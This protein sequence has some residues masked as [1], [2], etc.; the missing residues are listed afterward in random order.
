M[1]RNSFLEYNY[2]YDLQAYLF[3]VNHD[4]CFLFFLKDVHHHIIAL[5]PDLFSVPLLTIICEDLAVS[6]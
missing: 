4:S 1:I 6:L 2:Y 3:I 5:Q